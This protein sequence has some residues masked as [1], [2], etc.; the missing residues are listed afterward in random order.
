[1]KMKLIGSLVGAL[2]IAGANAATITLTN[3]DG[4]NFS[5]VVDS[6]GSIL[7]SV[8]FASIGTFS[9]DPTSIDD[10]SSFVQFGNSLS[11]G[12]N[13]FI[14]GDINQSLTSGDSYVGG[15]VYVVIG[16]GTDLAT[17][18]EF[19]VWKATSNPSGN[20]YTEDAP[21]GGPDTV[22]LQTSTGTVLIGGTT[23]A[24]FGGGSQTAFQLVAV[25]EPSVALLGALGLLGLARRRR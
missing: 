16:N 25:P 10:L 12:A 3:F 8:G 4:T 18:T 21:I 5:G 19:F 13:S 24:D 11:V 14:S 2:A 7:N 15:S 22:S 1:M 6:S 20:V 9:S 17:S 23:T